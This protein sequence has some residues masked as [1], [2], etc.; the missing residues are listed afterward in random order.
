MLSTVLR[1]PR[2]VQVNIEIMHTF[3]RVR[4]MLAANAELA[5]RLD[6]LEATYDAQFR[7]VFDAIRELMV[8]PGG[9]KGADWIRPIGLGRGTE[10]LAAAP[11]RHLTSPPRAPAASRDPIEHHLPRLHIARLD[12]APGD[13]HR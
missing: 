8:P 7:V 5:S 10:V 6:A 4:Q 2:A 12:V 11:R 9:T 13:G 1:S 3:V